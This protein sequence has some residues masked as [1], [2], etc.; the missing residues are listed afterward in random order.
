MTMAR[1]Q[2]EREMIRISSSINGK[3]LFIILESSR[4]LNRVRCFAWRSR[5]VEIINTQQRRRMISCWRPGLEIIPRLFNN[6]FIVNL[7]WITS[8]LGSSCNAG[9]L[10]QAGRELGEINEGAELKGRE[11]EGCEKGTIRS[12]WS[13][14]FKFLPPN[15]RLPE[16]FLRSPPNARTLNCLRRCK[17]PH[18]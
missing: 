17:I 3:A 16:D 7:V 4:G 8:W 15:R 2:C 1:E 10:D 9:L 5:I 18:D 13:N 6:F 14:V 12:F 11:I